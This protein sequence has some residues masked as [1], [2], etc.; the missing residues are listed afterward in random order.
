MWF[1]KQW[2]WNSFNAKFWELRK[3]IEN[4]NKNLFTRK[5]NSIH[6][7]I[8]VLI[9][10][11]LLFI[12]LFIYLFL[13]FIYW[14]CKKK[15]VF[16]HYFL[17]IDGA[18]KSKKETTRTRTRARR[19]GQRKSKYIVGVLLLLFLLSLMM[20]L[21]FLLLTCFYLDLSIYFS[22]I[23]EWKKQNNKANWKN[24]T[25]QKTEHRAANY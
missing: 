22:T 19:K 3:F 20:L 21:L 7:L 2:G 13:T 9:I 18:W 14:F 16:I 12:H 24:K 17:L 4:K 15:K 10:F 11:G 5:F 1:T 25:K 23:F 8:F 6:L